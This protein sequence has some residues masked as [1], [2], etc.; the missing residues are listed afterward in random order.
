MEMVK[1]G[2]AEVAG[3]ILT[4]YRTEYESNGSL[5]ILL[6]DAKEE[7]Y[8]VVSVNLVDQFMEENE[9][10]V[11]HDIQS[12]VAEDLL[13]CGLFEDTGRRVSYGFVES[14]PVWRLKA[15]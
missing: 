4:I 10:A 1:I 8:A 6:Y 2:T 15:A 5:G 14:R 7:P 12:I 9:F 3:E 13:K 11:H